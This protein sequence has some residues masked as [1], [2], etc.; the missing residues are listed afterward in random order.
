MPDEKIEVIA[1]G[2]PDFPFVEPDAAKA[3]LGFSGRSV[4]LTFGLL[5]PSKGIEV[6]IDAMPSILKRRPDAVYVVLGATHP[7][8][9]RDQ[10]EAYRESLMTR[11]RELG[12]EDHVVFLDQFV[13]QATLLEF[14]SMC[15]V[16]VTPYLNEAQMTSGT[17]AYSF[18]LGKPVVSTPYWHARELLADGRGVLVP[19]GDAAGIGNE[20]AQLLTDEPRR[21][22]MRER[23][24]A[25]S[26]SMT[27]E[28][29]AER[30]MTAFETCAAGPPAEG[31]RARRAG[32]DRAAQPRGGARHAIGP[33]SVDVRRYRPVP[34]RRAFGAGSRARLLRGR[35]CAR[36]AVGLR[37]Q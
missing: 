4:I 22:A 36:L 15:D 26:R 13:D 16:Y 14:I 31:D 23:A 5:S 11:V 30:Y 8:L 18:G 25:A 35:Q 7:N 27:W 20:I 34:A 10:G 9:V 37:T 21:Q 12:V 33:F 28:R 24:Y 6:M 3:R 2:I 17:L 29:T 1:H 19:F 32:R